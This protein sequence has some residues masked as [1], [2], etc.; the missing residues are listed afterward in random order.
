MRK[1]LYNKTYVLVNTKQIREARQKRGWTQAELAVQAGVGRHVVADWEAGRHTPHPEQVRQ[2]CR[3]LGM[4]V[5]DP[6]SML[7]VSPHAVDWISPA[8]MRREM[9]RQKLSGRRLTQIAGMSTATVSR[10]LAG[11]W[12]TLETVERLVSVLGPGIL[13]RGIRDV[14]KG[15]GCVS[16][17]FMTV[18]E[19]RYVFDIPLVL[20]RADTRRRVREAIAANPTLSAEEIAELAIW[21]IVVEIENNGLAIQE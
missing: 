11:E 17:E 6:V 19:Q 9:R 4:V 14:M 5:G 16:S 1:N 7:A 8:A 10:A 20:G 21:D 12:V 13:R 2:I 3:A 15:E 18:D